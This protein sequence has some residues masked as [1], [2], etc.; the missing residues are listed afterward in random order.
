MSEEIVQ[1]GEVVTGLSEQTSQPIINFED[2][3]LA[4]N[5]QFI[6]SVLE[7]YEFKRYL[8]D[9]TIEIIKWDPESMLKSIFDDANSVITQNNA[10]DII[11]DYKARAQL[12]IKLLEAAGIIKQKAPEVK[13]SFLN[14]LFWKGE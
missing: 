7:S 4:K 8:K 14:L 12:K 1:E 10:G 13:I 5:Q 9:G 3:K 2:K 11:P 6:K